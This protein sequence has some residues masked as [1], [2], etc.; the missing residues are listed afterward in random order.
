M[1]SFQKKESTLHKRI[2]F[3]RIFKPGSRFWIA[4]LIEADLNREQIGYTRNSRDINRTTVKLITDRNW[5]SIEFAKVFEWLRC[6]SVSLSEVIR[7]ALISWTR[8]T[9]FPMLDVVEHRSLRQSQWDVI[10]LIGDYLF[11]TL[12]YIFKPGLGRARS[13]FI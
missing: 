4:R 1:K 2:P 11:G 13:T 9:I 10:K 8:S 7:A 12:H 5:I 6:S 3:N